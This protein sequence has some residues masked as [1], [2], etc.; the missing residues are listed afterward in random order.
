MCVCVSSLPQLLNLARGIGQLVM[1]YRRV[2]TL[3]GLTTRVAELLE[4]V[5]SKQSEGEQALELLR[6]C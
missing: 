1:L 5:S 2:M 4:L 3:A 6:V